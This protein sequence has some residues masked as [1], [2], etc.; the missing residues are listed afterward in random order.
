[1]SSVKEIETQSKTRMEKAIA[2]FQ[3]EMSTLRT[4]RASINIL[5]GIRVDY[6]GTPSPFPNP[7]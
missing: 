1:M 2:D 6:Y 3:H 7:A 4:G 5:D